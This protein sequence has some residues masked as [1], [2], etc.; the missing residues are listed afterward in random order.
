MTRSTALFIFAVGLATVAI[1][2]LILKAAV[3]RLA[4]RWA[5][6]QSYSAVA[7]AT[8]A[9]PLLWIGVLLVLIGASCWYLA[10]MGLPLSLMMPMSGVI[11]PVVSVG[12]Y[13]VFGEA[14]SPAKC[15]AIAVIAAGVAWL[16]YLNT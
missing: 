13:L 2:Q 3:P 8:L 5:I 6:S 12:A 16:G 10:M 4:E 14:L 1:S 7:A 11:A 9:D 15:A